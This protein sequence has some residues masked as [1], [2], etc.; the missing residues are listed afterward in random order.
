MVIIDTSGRSRRQNRAGIYASAIL[1]CL[2]L[3]VAAL[4]L[5]IVAP[6]Q[7]DEGRDFD[8]ARPCTAQGGDDCLRSVR[9]TVAEIA[10]HRNRKGSGS[11]RLI[12]IQRDGKRA[13]VAF[14]GSPEAAPTVSVGRDIAVTYWRGQVRFAD[15]P[16]GRKYS[17]ADP[18]DDYRAPMAWGLPAG[19]MGLFG[20]WSW[21]WWAKLSHLSRLRYPWQL[22][23]PVSGCLTV[24]SIAGVAAMTAGSMG[25]AL[26]VTGGG[27]LVVFAV[28][29]VLGLI[30]WRRQRGDDTVAQRGDDTVAVEPLAPTAEQ[31]IQGVVRGEVSYANHGVALIAAPGSLAVSTGLTGGSRRELPSSLTPL[32]VRPEY[33]TDPGGSL[34]S[35]ETKP[36]VLECED[37]GVPVFI[38]ADRKD[39]PLILGALES[40]TVSTTA[41]PARPAPTP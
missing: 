26:R 29:L 37:N 11:Y 22:W 14:S 20:M 17:R 34:A 13:D 9:A 41:A 19:I 5:L 30:A 15:Y 21:L 25:A 40:R 36:L 35:K 2:A 8:A 1:G 32:R 33:W 3:A 16:S 38:T 23:V 27:A 10:T 39:L 28:T 6:V 24:A 12:L 18:R 7:L 31:V 4:L